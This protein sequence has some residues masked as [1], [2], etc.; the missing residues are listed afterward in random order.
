MSIHVRHTLPRVRSFNPFRAFAPATFGCEAGV[1]MSTR[2]AAKRSIRNAG[3][4]AE[5]P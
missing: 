5:E 4:A 3:I 2:S 1:P